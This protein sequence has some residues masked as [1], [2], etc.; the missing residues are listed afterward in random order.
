MYG[1]RKSG[2]ECY[3]PGGGEDHCGDPIMAPIYFVS[4]YL[5]TAYILIVRSNSLFRS[6]FSLHFVGFLSNDRMN[7]L[8]VLEQ[9]L[10]V[11][12]VLHHFS[13]VYNQVEVDGIHVEEIDV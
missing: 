10:F 1:V 8:D 9:N 2:P 11:T 6:F 3:N 12:I 5:F 13:H 4:F 7:C